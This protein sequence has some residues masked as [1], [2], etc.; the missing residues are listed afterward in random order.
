MEIRL[1]L[2]VPNA[3]LSLMVAMKPAQA[4]AK[5]QQTQRLSRME[6]LTFGMINT[7]IIHNETAEIVGY[8]VYWEGKVVTVC[9]IEGEDAVLWSWAANQQPPDQAQALAL[10]DEQW[11]IRQ[12]TGEK[13]ASLTPA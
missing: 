3:A 10:F 7:P 11:A 4:L 6:L 5:L 9:G 12:V 8:V 2:G 1:N 13:K